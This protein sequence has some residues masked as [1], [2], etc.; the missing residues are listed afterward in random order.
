MPLDFR[1]KYCAK[2]WRAIYSVCI[3]LV[4]AY[5]FLDVLD[6]DGSD[7]PLKLNPLERTAIITDVATGAEHTA[8][9]Q[10]LE[11][12]VDFSLGSKTCFARRCFN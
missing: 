5:V 2:F 7:F 4:F 8:A 9:P 10:Q 11:P 1:S 12:L 6:L 3:I